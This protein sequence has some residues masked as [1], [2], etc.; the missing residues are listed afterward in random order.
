MSQI[1]TVE[2]MGKASRR[3]ALMSLAGVVVV[4]L[5]FAYSAYELRSLDAKKKQLLIDITTLT[6]T[7]DQLETSIKALN[8]TKISPQGQV[9]QVK[10]SAKGIPGKRDAN[11]YPYYTFT[12][13]VD[14]SDAVLERIA[15]V[16]YFLNHPTFKDPHVEATKP[17]DKF[18]VQYNGW[19]CLRDVDVTVHFKDGTTQ[20]LAF[21]MCKSL[22]PEW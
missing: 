21:D 22:G 11:G 5:S 13:F 3:A 2:N 20:S 12:L 18:A 1:D 4:L 10:A 17:A 19:G 9:F 14:A 16:S 8:Y 7:K 15:K 6:T